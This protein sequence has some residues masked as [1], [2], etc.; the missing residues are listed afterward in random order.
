[1]ALPSNSLFDLALA[2]WESGAERGPHPAAQSRTALVDAGVLPAGRNSTTGGL[3]TVAVLTSYGDAEYRHGTSNGYGATDG[4]RFGVDNDSIVVILLHSQSTTDHRD[5]AYIA[6]INGGVLLGSPRAS[7]GTAVDV[8]GV[9]HVNLFESGSSSSEGHAAVAS[10]NGARGAIDPSAG[11]LT[12]AT[13]GYRDA[14]SRNV[15]ARSVPSAGGATTRS[16]DSGRPS[17]PFTGVPSLLVQGCALLL[18][19]LVAVVSIS[20]RRQLSGVK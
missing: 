13:R 7:P 4:V 18:G 5:N 9:L 20:R 15:S 19:T 11:V 17:I 14:A 10:L 3:L 8:P 2:S 6:S 12:A 16:R 1:M